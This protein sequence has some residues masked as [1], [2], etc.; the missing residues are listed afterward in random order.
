MIF[1]LDEI[2]NLPWRTTPRLKP[3][4]TRSAGR[5]TEKPLLFPTS[6]FETID[7]NQLVEEEDLP[8]YKADWFYPVKLGV[9]QDRYQII[10][11]LGF[12]SSSTS[13]LAW[14]LK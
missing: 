4:S 3:F 10:A 11:K 13:W 6:G 12:G 1:T 2:F 8:H 5:P 7:V 9:F 14:D